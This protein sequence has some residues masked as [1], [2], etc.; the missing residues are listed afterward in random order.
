MFNVITV[1]ASSLAPS[2]QSNPCI[3]IYYWALEPDCRSFTWNP[4]S[5]LGIFLEFPMLWKFV[6]AK[7]NAQDWPSLKINI[8]LMVF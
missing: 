6:M 2:I 3:S 4:P 8:N 7:L 5:K 1:G